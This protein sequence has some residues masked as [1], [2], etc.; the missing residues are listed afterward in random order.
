MITEFIV[1]RWRVETG[2]MTGVSVEDY[3]EFYLGGRGVKT[4]ANYE[5]AYKVLMGHAADIGTSVFPW[6]EGEIVG[7]VCKITKEKNG[8]NMMK[9]CNAVVNMLF[10]AAGFEAP[11]KGA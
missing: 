6:G 4:L 9:R 2:R 11:T 10:E 7:L 1:C 3:T 8:E 5:S